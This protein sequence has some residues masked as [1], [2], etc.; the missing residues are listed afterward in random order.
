MR[1]GVLQCYGC[2]SAWPVVNG[3][4]RLFDADRVRGSDRFLRF[5]YNRI[6]PV[7]D[8]AVRFAL[9]LMQL[10]SADV[11]RDGYM[12]QLDA[13]QARDHG[14]EERQ[15]ADPHP[16]GRD[17]RRREPAVDR[18]RRPD[19]SRLRGVG[20]GSQPG[21]ARAVPTARVTVARR[22]PRAADARGRPR[23]CRSRAD[24]SIASS[25]SAAST[26]TATRASRSPRWRG[27]PVP[28]TPI[29]VV[30]EQLDRA[31]AANPY[32]W[33]VFRAMTIYDRN[34]RAPRDLLPQGAELLCDSQVS[35]FYYCLTFCMPN[36]NGAAA[37]S[38]PSSVGPSTS[39]HPSLRS[40]HA[41]MRTRENTVMAARPNNTITGILRAT[42]S[43][44]SRMATTRR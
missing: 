18:A 31:A 24:R 19:A 8:L 15:T 42:A 25:T 35:R 30:D 32:Y 34:P 16:R 14:R 27:W 44:H 9:P 4:P 11:A 3:V 20:R 10:S 43:R 26:A 22:P 12:K 39:S 7:H 17:R 6:A 21:H 5:V 1:I 13:R 29:V 28:D 36:G 33:A 38:S 37:A 40:T 23:S 41:L 2:G